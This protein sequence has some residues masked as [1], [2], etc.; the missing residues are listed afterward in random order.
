MLNPE[1]LDTGLFYEMIDHC[2]CQFLGLKFMKQKITLK[3][4]A[5][6]FGVSISTVSKALKDSHEISLEVK[7]EFRPLPN[8]TTIS[9]IVWL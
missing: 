2:Q 4:I 1:I 5:K 7:K 9:Q 8:T 3:K 6:E